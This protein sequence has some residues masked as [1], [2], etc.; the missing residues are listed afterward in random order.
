[1]IMHL[2]R[3]SRVGDQITAAGWW[4]GVG[5]GMMLRR[6]RRSLCAIAARRSVLLRHE[7]GVDDVNDA[8][9]GHDIGLDDRCVVDLDAVARI[10]RQRAALNGL[11]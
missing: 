11:R 7:H 4:R 1:M 9:A 3:G 5:D 10:D 8:I 6:R 2:G